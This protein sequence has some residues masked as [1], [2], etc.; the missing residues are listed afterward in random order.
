[1]MILLV[2]M[3]MFYKNLMVT[4]MR[5]MLIMLLTNLMVTRTRGNTN[6]VVERLRLLVRFVAQLKQDAPMESCHGQL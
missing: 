5:T 2:T 3:M 6:I 1:M 4:S